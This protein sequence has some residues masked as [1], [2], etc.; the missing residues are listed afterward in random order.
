[1][2]KRI[3]HP[4]TILILLVVFVMSSIAYGFAAANV[5]PESGA[6]DGEGV[7]SGYTITNIKYDLD[8]TNPREID[9]V[10]F[11]I[12][13]TTS[14]PNATN[15]KITFDGSNWTNCDTDSVPLIVCT[16]SAIVTVE[17]VDNL[18]VVAVS[19]TP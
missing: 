8:D 1:M 15:V 18:R 16:M 13:P 10:Q 17:S 6:G 5:V 4:R 11:A 3:L 14:A 19:D 12:N 2:V 7:V 9:A